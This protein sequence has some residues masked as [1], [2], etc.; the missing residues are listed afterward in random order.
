MIRTK[1]QSLCGELDERTRRLWAASEARALGYG[2]IK[3]VSRATGMAVGT[4]RAGLR[5][6]DAPS[7]AGAGAAER[8]VRRPGAGRKPLLRTDPAMAEALSALVESTTRGDP[9]SPLLWTCK[10]T[11]VLAGELTRQGHRIGHSTVA[12][13]LEERG[14]S[15]QAARKSREGSSHPDRNAQFEHINAKVKAFQRRG[16]PVVSVDTKKKELVGNHRNPG[17]EWHRRGEPPQVDVHD[18]PEK[19]RGKAIPYGVFDMAANSGWVS[20]GTDHDT[21]EFAVAA[22]RQWWRR[23]GRRAYPDAG[24]LL[25]TADSG[26]SNG[27]RTRLWKV[28]LQRLADETG[29]RIAVCHFP[30]GT[31]KWNKIEHQMFCH[32]T[33]NWRG[34]PLETY[35]VVVN[36]IGHTTTRQGLTVKAALDTARYPQG[37]K[38]SDEQIAEVAMIPD[39]FHG[40]WNYR[41]SPI[42]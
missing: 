5:E 42:E 38:V 28:A 24:E 2:G 40:E 18:F 17:R 10:S 32:I 19:G 39:A 30:P 27:S 12:G 33:E 9:M 20:V 14:Y 23:M 36:L 21:A 34:R 41:I 25:I 22:I 11:R 31:S 1:F 29:L 15:L 6:L 35:G 8:R 26:G 16:L 13:L 4:V 37:I 7:R 3:A